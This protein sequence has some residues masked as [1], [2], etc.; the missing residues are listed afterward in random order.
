LPTSSAA[1]HPVATPPVQDDHVGAKS[2]LDLFD[3]PRF[4][5]SVLRRKDAG[6][7]VL[8]KLRDVL[9]L[10]SY[11][12][13]YSGVDSPGVALNMICAEVVGGLETGYIYIYIYI[14]KYASAL[15]QADKSVATACLISP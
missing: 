5:F 10:T 6:T 11:S 13:C 15:S 14:Y 9:S 7:D 2:L 12:T 3:W 4:F 8:M 1:P